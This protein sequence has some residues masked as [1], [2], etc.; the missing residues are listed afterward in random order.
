MVF[1]HKGRRTAVNAEVNS[2]L[3]C[4]IRV[5]LLHL[6]IAVSVSFTSSFLGGM[7]DR[8][9]LTEPRRQQVPLTDQETSLISRGD[10][11]L[12]ALHTQNA[13]PLTPDSPAWPRVA[14]VRPSSASPRRP[15]PPAGAACRREAKGSTLSPQSDLLEPEAPTASVEHSGLSSSP[16]S[17]R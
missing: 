12:L 6:F 16:L 10:N 3:M 15:L 8:H 5:L 9:N 1:P 13:F 7:W 2:A 11:Q 4:Q 17:H 14:S